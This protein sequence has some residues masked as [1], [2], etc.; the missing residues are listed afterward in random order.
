MHDTDLRRR[1]AVETTVV[2][3]QDHLPGRSSRR[4][5]PEVALT[6]AWRVSCNGAF[7]DQED[8][9]DREDQTDLGVL[10][11]ALVRRYLVALIG[12][13]ERET[14]LVWATAH[15]VAGVSE[16]FR[17]PPKRFASAVS[18][19]WR[20]ILSIPGQRGVDVRFHERT[21]ELMD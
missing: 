10:S 21:S 4:S 19:I 3:D 18:R 1:R 12:P 2:G 11:H 8:L 6:T 9:L 16:T 17:P 5:S 7:N 20:Y 13:A 14:R 15:V